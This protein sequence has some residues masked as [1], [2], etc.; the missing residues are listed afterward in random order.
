MVF[1]LQQEGS[2]F[3]SRVTRSLGVFVQVPSQTEDTGMN[4]LVCD[5]ECRWLFVS[6]STKGGAVDAKSELD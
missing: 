5:G 2:G 4:E 6:S 3:A 1:T